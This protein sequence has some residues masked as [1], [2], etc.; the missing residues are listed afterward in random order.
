MSSREL[1]FEWIPRRAGLSETAARTASTISTNGQLEP[2]LAELHAKL[3]IAT[4]FYE[5]REDRRH[6][7]FGAL[8]EVMNFLESQGIPRATMT[9]LAALSAALVDADRGITSPLFKA[10]T[11]VGAPPSPFCRATSRNNWQ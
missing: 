11:K 4:V 3:A 7:V 2:A 10:D 9:P 1:E 8:A 6:S 5:R